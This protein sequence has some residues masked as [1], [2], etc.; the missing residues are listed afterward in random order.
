MNQAAKS[1]W[2]L[3]TLLA[4]R[5]VT[6][7]V[8]ESRPQIAD[9]Q[10]ATESR[11]VTTRP[12]GAERV[13]AVLEP[14]R[15][16]FDVPA[17]AVAAS[18][19]GKMVGIGATG[20]RRR[21][22]DTK[23][24]V[25]DL[26]HLGS[27]TKAMT[28][29]LCAILIERGTL[30]WKTTVGA[31][32]KDREET[33]HADW[34]G[35]T[36]DQLLTNSSGAPNSLD[37]GGLWGRLWARQGSPLEQRL[38]LL[39]GVITRAPEAKPGTKFIY[40]NAGFSIAGAIAERVTK[41]PW[42]TLIKREVFDPLGMES[43]GF[44]APGVADRL[45]QPRGHHGERGRQVVEP[46]PDADNPPAI[47]PAGVVHCTIADWLKFAS[48]HAT[49]E[50]GTPKLLKA[51]T[52]KRLHTP[53][54]GT[55]A[56]GWGTAKR[57]WAHGGVITHSGSN[58]SWYCVTWIAPERGFAVVAATNQADERARGAVDEA[59]STMIGRYLEP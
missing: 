7:Q 51:E 57:P 59:C 25:D 18:V 21:G 32:F 36:L 34:A 10:P 45:D 5:F 8:P 26:W 20:F 6:G 38:Q 47:G 37:A 29:T 22:D 23:V 19:N 44:G 39:D 12:D 28:A 42:E 56:F 33:M 53:P 43:A 14:I 52:I 13:D 3:V 4:C 49:G 40:S 50:K 48:L 41:T 2:V 24:T 58:T 11:A 35:V 16:R 30:D 55:Y 9:S 27:C 46:G 1:G 15:V 31:T 17:L 54:F